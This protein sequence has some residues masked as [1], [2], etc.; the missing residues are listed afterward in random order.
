MVFFGERGFSGDFKNTDPRS[1]DG[2]GE[3]GEGGGGSWWCGSGYL[4][5]KA[6]ER[7]LERERVKYD[8]GELLNPINIKE[9]NT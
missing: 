4:V 2:R 7:V 8:L 5:W 6:R 9:R 3:V 1:L